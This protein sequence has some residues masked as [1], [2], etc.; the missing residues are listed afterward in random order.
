MTTT[1]P[2][3]QQSGSTKRGDSAATDTGTD[4]DGTNGASANA[5]ATVKRGFPKIGP[6]LPARLRPVNRPTMLIEI[7]LVLV[8]YYCYRVTQNAASHGHDAPFHRG[9]DILNLEQTLHIDAEHWLNHTVDKI[10]WLIVGM[11]YYYATLHFI[12]T[13]GVFIWVYVK[14]PERYR[15]IRT[16]MFAMNAVAL[17][18]FYLYAVAPPRLLDPSH[19]IDTFCVHHTWGRTSC[20]G[21]AG[22]SGSV[23]NE[24]AAM[25]SLHIGWAL[26]CGLAMAHLAKRKWVKVVGILYPVATFLVIITTAQHYVLDMVGGLMVLAA[27]FLVQRILLG[28]PAYSA[29]PPMELVEIP[30][31]GGS[32]ANGT[33]AKPTEFPSDGTTTS[34]QT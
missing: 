18:V 1:Q 2:V 15:A 10:T 24:Y 12:V 14:F 5:G 33:A 22:L 7:V 19:F 25:P 29:P 3:D 9:R 20:G 27:G 17:I 8:G 6:I 11:N 21:V 13:I 16:A 32:A 28:R 23:T 26:W 34:A 4:T 31:Q 30:L